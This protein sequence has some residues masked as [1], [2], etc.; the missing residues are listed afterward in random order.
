MAELAQKRPQNTKNGKMGHFRPKKARNEK[1]KN[2]F[3][4]LPW[5]GPKSEISSWKLE[6]WPK[7]PKKGPKCQKGLFRAQKRSKRRNKKSF[8]FLPRL[9]PKSKISSRNLEKWPKW[10]KKAPKMPKMGHFGPKKAQN[11]KIKN[12]FFSF[13]EWVLNPKFQVESL[14]NGRNRVSDR[15]TTS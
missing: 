5:M 11:K 10:P 14:K 1:I 15:K 12:P 3:F 2:P 4:F 13:P 7:W 6:K 9:G 8:F